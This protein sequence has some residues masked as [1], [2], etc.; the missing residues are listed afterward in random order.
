MKTQIFMCLCLIFIKGVCGAAYFS[1]SISSSSTST[2]RP[3]TYPSQPRRSSTPT[4][5]YRRP[6]ST[7]GTGAN[8]YNTPGYYHNSSSILSGGFYNYPRP[9]G[10]GTQYAYRS[11]GAPG[12]G[13]GG[14]G[15]ASAGILFGNFADRYVGSDRVFRSSGFG[16]GVVSLSIH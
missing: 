13:A 12:A 4:T 8:A 10:M 5:T 3:L 9:F 6:T 14:I 11:G 15:A 2:L 1:S 7:Y 16:D